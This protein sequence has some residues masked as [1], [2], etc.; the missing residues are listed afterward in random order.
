MDTELSS[1]TETHPYNLQQVMEELERK[2]LHNILTQVEWDMDRASQ[3]LEI[4]SQALDQKMR[5]YELR[6]YPGSNEQHPFF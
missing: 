5:Q 1:T 3:M 4:S 6:P 2:Y